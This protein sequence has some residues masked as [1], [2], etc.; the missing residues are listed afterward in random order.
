[1]PAPPKLPLDRKLFRPGERI[2]IAVSAGADSVPLQ[3]AMLEAAEEIGLVLSIIH[4]HHNLRGPD[5]DA[6]AAFVRDLANTH[7]LH[8]DLA[9]AD[10]P[11]RIAATGQ[12]TELAA[13]HLRY[14]AF[15]R[16]LRSGEIDA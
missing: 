16:L 10:T 4:V 14:E 12:S 6:D 3:R 2:A 5:A 11:A 13:R 1:M 7:H 15:N 8:L 9:H